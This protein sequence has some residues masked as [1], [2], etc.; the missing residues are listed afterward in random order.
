MTACYVLLQS[1]KANT[2]ERMH[3]Y[4]FTNAVLMCQLSSSLCT[5]LVLRDIVLQ[6]NTAR[7]EPDLTFL[8]LPRTYFAING[9]E[10]GYSMD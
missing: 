7:Y 1:E 2:E 3:L 4:E 5:V 10:A 8:T 9:E 6:L